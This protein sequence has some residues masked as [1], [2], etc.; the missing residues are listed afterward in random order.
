MGFYQCFC[1][2]V[3]NKGMILWFLTAGWRFAFCFC[4]VFL[5]FCTVVLTFATLKLAPPSLLKTRKFFMEIG[6]KLL[7]FAIVQAL[8][9][10][11]ERTANFRV[12]VSVPQA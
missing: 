7:I 10:R 9:E 6:F 12:W 8:R 4:E 11:N 5:T 3:P 2:A 1:F